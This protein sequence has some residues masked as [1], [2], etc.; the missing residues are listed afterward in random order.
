M[1]SKLKRCKEGCLKCDEISDQCLECAIDKYTLQKEVV[2]HNNHGMNLFSGILEIFFGFNIPN[3]KIDVTEIRMKTECLDKCPNTYGKDKTPVII[4]EAERKCIVKMSEN[5]T[6][7]HTLPPVSEDSDIHKY[8]SKLKITYDEAIKST[9]KKSLASKQSGQSRECHYNGILKKEIRGDLDSYYICRCTPEYMGDNCQIPITLYND[10][11]EKIS[12]ILTKIKTKFIKMDKR[13][14]D[15]FLDYL[16]S[17][18]KFKLNRSTLEQIIAIVQTFIQMDKKL[19]NKKKLY[20]L[21]DSLLLNLFDLRED[22]R[23][24]PLEEL[25]Y[26]KDI[27][28][29]INALF[30]DINHVLV[31]LENSLEDINFSGS[32][33]DKNS[34]RYIG[35]ETYSYILVEYQYRDYDNKDGFMISNPNIDTSFNNVNNNYVYFSFN[36]NSIMDASEY[37]LQMLNIA[38]PL[39]TENIKLNRKDKS[40][41]ATLISNVLYLRNIDLKNTHLKIRMSDIGVNELKIEFALNFIPFVDFQKENLS[42]VGYSITPGILNLE[43][44]C[45]SYDDDAETA[46]CI[47]KFTGEIEGYYFGLEASS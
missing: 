45:D 7:P 33:L 27:D 24:R 23:K 14:R 16:I 30:I 18:N 29:E 25:M 21:Y 31:M 44:E 39:F 43:G 3:P 34:N 10:I 46:V 32:F 8:I 11:Q 38:S 37:N 9:E 12:K 13:S 1:K 47:F 22:A 28:D 42:C 6:V 17:L 26:I 20:L 36:N 15:K 5:E 41:K 4:H 35:L 2:V 19:E 40:T